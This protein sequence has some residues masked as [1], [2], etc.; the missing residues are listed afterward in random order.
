LLS[1]KSIGAMSTTDEPSKPEDVGAEVA[2]DLL[3]GG[4]KKLK[5]VST[6]LVSFVKPGRS[7][8]KVVWRKQSEYVRL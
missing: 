6:S 2:H 1:P 8:S 4:E 3:L 5:I 7:G